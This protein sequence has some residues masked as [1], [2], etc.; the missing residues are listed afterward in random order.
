MEV[1]QMERSQMVRLV[2]TVLGCG[3]LHGGSGVPG[4]VGEHAGDGKEHLEIVE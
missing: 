1:D 4:G 2:R 3:E